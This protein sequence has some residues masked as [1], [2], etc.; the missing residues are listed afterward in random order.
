MKGSFSPEFQAALAGLEEHGVSPEHARAARTVW[1]RIVERCGDV[2]EP[3]VEIDEDADGT[4]RFA[5]N[6]GRYYLDVE[7]YAD[8]YGE[9]TFRDREEDLTDCFSGEPMPDFP[10]KFWWY[11]KIA[12]TADGPQQGN[13][14]G[15]EA[16][17]GGSS[18]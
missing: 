2:R 7:V 5:W 4:V 17:E 18:R 10:E 1:S 12:A 8:G 6:R 3:I 15:A 14:G 13:A 9:W 16:A 11:A